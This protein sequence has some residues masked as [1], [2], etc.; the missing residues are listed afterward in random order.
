M[1]GPKAKVRMAS[2][3]QVVV[4]GGGIMGCAVAWRAAQAGLAVTLVERASLGQGSTRA[5]GGI[6]GVQ[7]E[8]PLGPLQALCL[9]SRLQ[10][11]AFVRDVAAQAGFTVPYREGGSLTLGADPADT[12]R[13]R[14]QVDAD[15]AAGRPAQWLTPQQA[16][17]QWPGLSVPDTGAALF[18]LDGVV[19]PP[20]LCRALATAARRAGATVLENTPVSQVVTTA[21]H[22]K[23]VVTTAATLPADAVVVC[24]GAWSTQLPEMGLPPGAVRPVRGQMVALHHAEVRPPGVVFR[25]HGY[26]V[27]REDGVILAGSTMEERGFE[28]AV[29]AEGLTRLLTLAQLLYPALKDATVVDT[30]SGL[31][32]AT[33]DGLPILGAGDVG[34]LVWATGHFRNGILLT[35]ITAHLVTQVLLGHTPDV[36]LAPFSP[37]RPGLRP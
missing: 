34:G 5:A 22:V 15:A 16:S 28:T 18:P 27:P 14:A 4:V 24:A 11:A 9:A 31:R 6:L 12:A 37:Q 10:Y 20:A 35:P 19:D 23:R 7:A 2:P 17:Q 13:R 33:P 21:G 3:K 36:D 25:G 26:L 32:P 30:W 8:G 29:T 1:N